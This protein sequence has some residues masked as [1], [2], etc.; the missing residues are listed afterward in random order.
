MTF[1]QKIDLL[2]SEQKKTN[3]KLSLIFAILNSGNRNMATGDLLPEIKIEED[4]ITIEPSIDL[5]FKKIIERNTI[6]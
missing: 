5:L 3:Q 6:K 1:E 2:L 4:T